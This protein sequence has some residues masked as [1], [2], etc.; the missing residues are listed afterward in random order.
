MI[1]DTYNHFK[2]SRDSI[3]LK[4]CM[5]DKTLDTLRNIN[6]LLYTPMY[7]KKIDKE[8]QMDV[9][10]LMIACMVTNSIVV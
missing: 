4:R 5:C 8:M 3:M 7:R 2:M 6:K 10:K 1:D 9:T